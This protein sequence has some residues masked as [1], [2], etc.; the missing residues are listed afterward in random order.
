MQK[1]KNQH[2]PN[3]IWKCKVLTQLNSKINLVDINQILKEIV[4]Y[5]IQDGELLQWGIINI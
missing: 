2:N 4:I 1:L 3:L 5:N